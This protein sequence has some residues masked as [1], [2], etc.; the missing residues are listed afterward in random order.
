MDPVGALGALCGALVRR[1]DALS[2]RVLALGLDVGCTLVVG[3]ARSARGVGLISPRKKGSPSSALA[4][5]LRPRLEGAMLTEAR[6]QDSTLL[7]SFAGTGGAATLACALE[8]TD[9]ALALL[10]PSGLVLVTTTPRAHPLGEPFVAAAARAPLALPQSLAELEAAGEALLRAHALANLDAR[11]RALERAVRRGL[12]R[13]T[14]RLDAIAQDLAASA[15]AGTLRVRASLLLA[16][17]HE[18][19]ADATEVRLVDETSD[20]PVAHVVPL[21]R[22]PGRPSGPR[23]AIELAQKLFVRARKLDTGARIA[24]ERRTR[25]LEERAQLTALLERV[26]LA[27]DERAL[28]TLASQAHAL[29]VVGAQSSLAARADLSEKKRR[30]RPEERV[31]YRRFL[32]TGER[33]VLVGRGAADNDAL[34]LRHARSQDLWLHAR[35]V[36]GAHI[37]V[38]LTRGEVCPPELLLDAATLAAHFSDARGEPIVEVQHVPRRYVRKPRGSAPGAVLVDREKVV[39]LRLEPARLARLL[40]RESLT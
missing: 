13:A 17:A 15:E 24:S 27:P 26:L 23:A 10:D 28:V 3:T 35:G 31:P 33:P 4:N 34:T 1:V 36:P 32:A 19:P 2:D 25:T 22:E 30:A 20:V 16:H 6:V 5:Q 14:R 29:G 7:L 11:R 18:V 12:E 21:P 37:V 39:A 40:A 38:P 8:G 9:G